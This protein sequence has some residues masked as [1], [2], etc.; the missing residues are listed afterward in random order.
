MLEASPAALA[1]QLA[2]PAEVHSDQKGDGDRQEDSVNPVA[3]REVPKS[4]AGLD[5]ADNTEYTIVR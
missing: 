2:F 4:Y 3:A 1:L 5:R